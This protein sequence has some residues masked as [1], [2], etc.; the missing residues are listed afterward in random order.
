[1]PSDGAGGGGDAGGPGATMPERP[2]CPGDNP[3]TGEFT[4][5]FGAQTRGA[6]E[7]IAKSGWF[8]E[9]VYSP[10]VSREIEG[11]N[12]AF[13]VFVNP[14]RRPF[15][16]RISEGACP[17][18]FPLDSGD[19]YVTK[20]DGHHEFSIGMD[21]DGFLHIVGDMHNHPFQGNEA[22]PA[23]YRTGKIMY[24]KSMAPHDVSAFEYLGDDDQKRP[25][26]EGFSYCSFR[27]DRLDALYLI[28]RTR[29]RGFWYQKGGRGLG[30]WKFNAQGSSSQSD[31][32]A[33]TTLG[34]T[35]D[36]NNPETI[37]VWEDSGRDGSS[38]QRFKGDVHV[39]AQNRLHVVTAIN[40]ND[41]PAD[42]NH[43]VY[44]V[45]EDGGQTFHKADGTE[46]SSLPLG[47][48]TADVLVGGAGVDVGQ[49]SVAV[50]GDGRPVVIYT[51]DERPV[52][53]AFN[54]ST[55]TEPQGLFDTAGAVP[56]MRQRLVF[57]ET[58]GTLSVIAPQSR[59][60]N[61]T[62]NLTAATP[63][64]TRTI[65]PLPVRYLDKSAFWAST[66]VTNAPEVSASESL[67]ANTPWGVTWSTG[68]G[69]FRVAPVALP[70]RS[71]PASN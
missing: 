22:H 56:P 58:T 52:F 60:V 6:F 53:Q 19:D 3:S 63:D 29:A 61:T 68:S 32:P 11:K 64:W 43:V 42:A 46:I 67:P 17:Q 18:V 49:A 55:W 33:W 57:D 26:G 2:G 4:G 54:G 39:D 28:C 65:L 37:L 44:A 13:F 66:D 35:P 25:G 14:D 59:Q 36:G 9:T 1:M 41:D 47:L 12:T 50:N 16:G 45:S 10:V 62:S 24:W 15:V 70:G 23:R 40:G 69:K 48:S 34:G 71:Q 30:L 51:L 38:Y 8:T 7:T 5:Q 31:S 27:S 20:D 21:A